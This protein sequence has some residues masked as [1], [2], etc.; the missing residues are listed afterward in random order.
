MKYR[1]LDF[2]KW[3]MTNNWSVE[4]LKKEKEIARK[5]LKLNK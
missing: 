2:I 1:N 4:F 5:L 3:F